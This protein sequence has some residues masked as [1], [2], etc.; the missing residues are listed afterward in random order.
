M[1]NVSCASMYPFCAHHVNH[2]HTLC[3]YIHRYLVNATL[4]QSVSVLTL[5]GERYQIVTHTRTTTT[6]TSTTRN[7]SRQKR[8]G[9]ERAKSRKTG[10]HSHVPHNNTHSYTL[11]KPLKKCRFPPRCV[12]NVCQGF[13][14]APAQSARRERSHVSITVCSCS[15][16]LSIYT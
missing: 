6:S 4:Q 1:V 9:R 11:V 14:P 12:T 8:V 10:T 13:F 2:I 5:W 16:L 3:T 15:S 7:K